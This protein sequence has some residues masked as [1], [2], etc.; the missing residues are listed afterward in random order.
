LT[1]QSLGRSVDVIDGD[2]SHALLRAATPGNTFPSS[3]SNDAPPPVEQCDTLSSASYF[4]QAVAVSPPVK[5][6][7]RSSKLKRKKE[8]EKKG[9]K[10]TEMPYLQQ[11]K[12]LPFE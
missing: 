4:A 9:R 10:R 5:I 8:K 11:S 12:L 3:S 2:A 1:F 7:R 6:E